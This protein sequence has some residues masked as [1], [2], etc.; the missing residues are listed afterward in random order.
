MGA[1]NSGEQI[2]R[3]D[4]FRKDFEIV[5]L[6]TRIAEQIG[7]GSEAGEEKD[8]AVGVAAANAD[9][10]VDAIHARH[11]DVTDDE[12]GRPELALL[13]RCA[14]IVAGG[15][16]ISAFAE[17]GA[18]GIGDTGLIVDD[19]NALDNRALQGFTSIPGCGWRALEN[20]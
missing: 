1:V 20:S 16:I 19:E 5:A 13:Q 3:M 15:S 9:C 8:L 14:R 10:H 12:I 17:D 4:G 2:F 6:K 11:D 18:E 7:C